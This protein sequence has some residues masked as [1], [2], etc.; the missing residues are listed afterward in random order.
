MDY[1][2]RAYYDAMRRSQEASMRRSQ[3]QQYQQQQTRASAPSNPYSGG[4]YGQQQRRP[5]DGYSYQQQ[6]TPGTSRDSRDS[7]DSRGS[8]GSSDGLRTSGGAEMA[9]VG[10]FFQQE[11][12]TGKVYVANIVQ[13]GSA[14][15][16]GVIRVNDVIVKVDDEDV[17]GQPLSTLRNLILGKQGSYV[18]L[19]FR[20]MTGTELYYFDVELVRGS[21]EYFESLKKSQAIADEKDKL[22]NQVRQQEAEIQQLKQANTMI[23]TSASSQSSMSTRAAAPPPPPADDSAQRELMEKSKEVRGLEE[24]LKAAREDAGN[25]SSMGV[26][27]AEAV[28]KLQSENARLNDTLHAAKMSIDTIEKRLEG[29]QEMWREEVRRLE[30]QLRNRHNGSKSSASNGEAEHERLKREVA[31]RKARSEEAARKLPSISAGLEAAVVAQED[32]A[33]LISD[34]IPAVD[35]LHS[36]IFATFAGR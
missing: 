32:A 25:A 19:A 14:D 6:Y 34:I 2:Q 35:T 3:E 20:R 17:Q 8:R 10:I 18:V 5:G 26:D 7:R 27:A 15:R 9:G 23:R 13:G 28:R 30:A 24:K 4:S 29:D 1:Q 12:N 33:T 16:S 21:P 36:Q 11:P 31:G 22:I